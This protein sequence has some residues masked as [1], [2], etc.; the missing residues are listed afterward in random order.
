MKYER[1]NC[2]KGMKDIITVITEVPEK[3]VLSIF[4]GTA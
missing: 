4:L 2:V 1:K 3:V